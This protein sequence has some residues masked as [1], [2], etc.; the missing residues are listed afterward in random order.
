MGWE[1]D[2]L[3]YLQNNMR[4]DLADPVMSFITHTGD[5]GIAY[6]ALVLILLIIPKSRRIG[7]ITA[8]SIA[9]E[10]LVTNLVIK[11]LVARPRPFDVIEGL[12]TVIKRPAD[13]SFPSGHTGAAFALAGAVLFIA[14]LGFPVA[15]KKGGFK[16]EKASK[17]V[18]LFAALMLV[19]SVVLAFTRMYVGVHYPTDVLGGLLIGTGTSILAYFIY[20][21]AVRKIASRKALIE[22]EEV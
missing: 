10:S 11:N 22:T 6:I 14:L 20:H 16:R 12:E 7:I 5:K 18:K 13:Y 4:S 17:A 19:Y 8:I 3:L 2:I 15:A 9:V 1:A 21:L